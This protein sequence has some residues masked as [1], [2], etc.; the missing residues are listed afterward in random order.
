L[1]SA[2]SFSADYTEAREKFLRAAAAAGG[3]LESL[4]HPERGPGG[5]ALHCDVA[6]FGPRTAERVLVLISGTHGIEGFCGSGVQT[7]WLRRGEAARLP[8]GV[9]ALVIHAINPYGFA[10]LRRVTEDNVDLNRN[11]IDFSRGLPENPAYDELAGIVT[12]AE[13]SPESIARMLTTLGSIGARD[14]AAA[15]QRALS[16]GQYRH[17]HGIFYGG[18]GPTWS[19]RSQTAIFA[20]YLGRAAHIAILDFHTGLGPHGFGEQITAEPRE[21]TSFKRAASW[22]GAAL[23]S[24]LDGSSSSSAISGDGLSAAP[25]LLAQ[26]KVTGIALEFGTQPLNEVILALCA[27]AWLHA[28]GEMSALGRSIK[29][30]MRAAFYADADDW[31]GMVTG[32]SLIACR[33]AI[34]GLLRG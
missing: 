26:A 3:A 10:W 11:W 27:D 28:H 18:A 17:P 22:F 12:P 8:H 9:A 13:W 19:R 7:D 31:K 25:T 4:A 32:Q 30:Q 16:G 33:Q 34:A 21:S 29:A 1:N 15:L 5:A 24:V 23:T 6:W 20:Q 14:G 2:E